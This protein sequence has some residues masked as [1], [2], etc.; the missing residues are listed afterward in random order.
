MLQKGLQ[1]LAACAGIYNVTAEFSGG[2]DGLYQ[3]SAGSTQFRIGIDS[4]PV[5]WGIAKST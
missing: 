4:L 2:Q 3:S 1:V 5:Q